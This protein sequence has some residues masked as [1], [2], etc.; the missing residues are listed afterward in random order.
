[1]RKGLERFWLVGAA[2]AVLLVTSP[3]IAGDDR[4]EEVQAP[5][6]GQPLLVVDS[7]CPGPDCTADLQPA[8]A[9]G[10]RIVYLNFEGVTLTYSG[11]N[12][13]AIQNVSAIVNGQTE[14]IAPF[15]T[16]DLYSTGG[17][18]RQQ[19]IARVVSDMYT[20]HD[21]FDVEFVTQRPAS[22]SYS[23]VVFGSSCGA[24]IGSNN[25]A[26]VA[27]RDCGDVMP[28]NIT[29]VFP[30]GL[31]VADLATTAAQEAAH[32]FGLGH[33]DDQDD[34]M[35][36]AIQN[37]IPTQF[38]AGSIPDNSGC[39][40][41]TYQDSYQVM[42]N[43]IGPRGQDVVGPSIA[44]TSPA[45]GAT[46]T[47][48]QTVVAT[49]TDASG[50][51]RAVLESSGADQTRN[52]PPWEF[53][54]PADVTAGEQSLTVRAHDV[55]GNSNFERIQVYVAGGDEAPCTG[56][57]DCDAGFE[58]QDLV[59]VPDNGI[60]GE[61]GDIC[62][63]GED[64]LAGTTCGTLGDESRCTRL[65]DEASPCPDGFDCLGG[66]ACWP[67][68]EGGSSGGICSAGGARNLPGLGLLT[69]LLGL[70]LSRRRPA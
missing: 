13:D 2:G 8:H 18:S 39:G 56:D 16:G 29:F 24:V 3:A 70:I 27:L 33:T 4:P 64:C 44:I 1:M 6:A 15:S 51:D 54:I 42:M 40:T 7:P 9:K 57:D 60:D 45:E 22:G 20:L 21:A 69:L 61:L 23:M 32:A 38:G 34:V 58:C 28:N 55:N 66:G 50:I 11:T 36:P 68:D 46:V 47:P 59:C 5:R 49:I 43:T 17:L 62:V 52:S 41:A 65:C 37:Y 19:I 26:G 48:G 10:Q 25:C 53:T 14:V 31:R 30:P 12:D 63:Q 67:A 35:Y